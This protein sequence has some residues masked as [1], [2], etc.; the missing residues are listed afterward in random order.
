MG[1]PEGRTLGIAVG[2]LLGLP[3]GEKV[4][5]IRNMLTATTLAS[6]VMLLNAVRKGSVYQ[7][8]NMSPKLTCM[9]SKEYMTTSVGSSWSLLRSLWELRLSTVALRIVGMQP[10]MLPFI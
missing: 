1:A 6:S 9:V 7:G 5:N 2:V 10:D 4:G 3:L 8:C